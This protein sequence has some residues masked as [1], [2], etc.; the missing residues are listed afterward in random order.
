MLFGLTQVGI[1]TA[2]AQVPVKA[3]KWQVIGGN[4][5]RAGFEIETRMLFAE[6]A[7]FIAQRWLGTVPKVPFSHLVFWLRGQQARASFE[8]GYSEAPGLEEF[9]TSEMWAKAGDVIFGERIQIG[10]CTSFRYVKPGSS[11]GTLHNCPNSDGFQVRVGDRACNVPFISYRL[12]SD[13]RRSIDRTTDDGGF[14]LRPTA[15]Q[16]SA[17]VFVNCSRPLDP[18]TLKLLATTVAARMPIRRL[19]IEVR[20]DD[21]FVHEDFDRRFAFVE[22]LRPLAYELWKQRWWKRCW[23]EKE[24]QIGCL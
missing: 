7:E 16:E 19:S 23:A 11:F 24:Q 9:S 5:L 17:T 3:P 14:V 13:Q 2:R 10:D 4:Y 15:G 22:A 21:Y 8:G 6:S 18:D 20:A 1:V 12:R